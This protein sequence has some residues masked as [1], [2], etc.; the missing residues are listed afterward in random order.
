MVRNTV[1]KSKNQRNEKSAN[2]KIYVYERVLYYNPWIR[3]ISCHYGYVV[4]K[5]EQ[6]DRKVKKP[7]IREKASSIGPSYPYWI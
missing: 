5:R 7:Y 3:N 4:E 6:R 1:L 2:G